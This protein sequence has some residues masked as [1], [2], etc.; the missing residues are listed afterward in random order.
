MAVGCIE[1]A[2]LLEEKPRET[3]DGNIF[4]YGVVTKHDLAA[5]RINGQMTNAIA[6]RQRLKTVCLLK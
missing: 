4:E 5:H 1:Y 6:W 2:V 3:F